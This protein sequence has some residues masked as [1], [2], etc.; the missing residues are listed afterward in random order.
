MPLTGCHLNCA[1]DQCSVPILVDVVPD[2]FGSSSRGS[3]DP[4]FC[5]S[6]LFKE[7]RNPARLNLKCLYVKER[8][9]VI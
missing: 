5:V 8:F 7:H 3:H 4:L 1:T 6:S 2:C 9:E